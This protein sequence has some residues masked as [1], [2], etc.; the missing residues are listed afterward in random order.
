MFSTSSSAG[1]IRKLM[2]Y[3]PSDREADSM[4]PGRGSVSLG[5]DI[6]HREI[7]LYG[8]PNYLNCSQT[9]KL[10]EFSRNIM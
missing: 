1:I 3:G 4:Q 8:V 7:T 10:A 6:G 5:R 2:N 9:A